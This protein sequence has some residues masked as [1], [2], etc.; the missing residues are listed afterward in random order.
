M[1]K[2]HIFCLGCHDRLKLKLI[3]TGHMRNGVVAIG[4]TESTEY[5]HTTKRFDNSYRPDV[6]MVTRPRALRRKAQLHM[7][8]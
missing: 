1:V 4:W 7:A 2:Q 3:L 8:V 5:R 6:I